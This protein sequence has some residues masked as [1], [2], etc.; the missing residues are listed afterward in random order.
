M[1]QTNEG[2][3]RLLLNP[4]LNI[5]K[6]LTTTESTWMQ[7]FLQYIL[8][9][10]QQPFS[11]KEPLSKLHFVTFPPHPNAMK[12]HQLFTHTYLACSKFLNRKG[13]DHKK[14]VKKKDTYGLSAGIWRNAEMLLTYQCLHEISNIHFELKDKLIY[15][16]TW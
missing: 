5:S 11:S 13:N 9:V 15:S 10:F 16:N 14:A 4:S 3:I 7:S 8:H 1:K 12:F 2:E 6:I